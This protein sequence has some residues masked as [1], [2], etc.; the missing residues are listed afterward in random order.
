MYTMLMRQAGPKSCY[1]KSFR[2]FYETF[3]IVVCFVLYIRSSS[4]IPADSC[5]LFTKDLKEIEMNKLMKTSLK[6]IRVQQQA[7]AQPK[8]S[9]T[10]TRWSRE[11]RFIGRG[12]IA[13]I[14]RGREVQRIH[15]N[16]RPEFSCKARWHSYSNMGD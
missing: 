14:E 15:K 5:I 8:V 11:T 10:Q 1:A 2:S 4:A 7:A 16:E 3:W 12:E 9:P 6:S 13:I